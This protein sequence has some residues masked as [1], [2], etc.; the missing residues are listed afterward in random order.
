MD[1]KFLAEYRKH[2]DTPYHRVLCEALHLDAAELLN[3]V[4]HGDQSEYS[5]AL[6]RLRQQIDTTRRDIKNLSMAATRL[7]GQIA[8]TARQLM[9]FETNPPMRRCTVTRRL[10]QAGHLIEAASSRRVKLT[11]EAKSLETRRQQSEQVLKGFEAAE[12]HL[13]DALQNYLLQ[14]GESAVAPAPVVHV[15]VNP[16]ISFPDQLRITSLPT[17]ETISSVERDGS[18]NITRTTQVERDAA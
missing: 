10:I 12:K 2:L 4:R 3:F 7:H 11:M 17:R 9:E 13:A 5:D 8:A 16:E 15:T 1:E 14:R 6:C 18:G